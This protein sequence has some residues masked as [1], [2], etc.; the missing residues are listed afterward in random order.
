MH[1]SRQAS[2]HRAV[3]SWKYILKQSLCPLQLLF[4]KHS[5]SKV[6]KMTGC[7]GKVKRDHRLKGLST[8]RVWH[9]LIVAVL[10]SWIKIQLQGKP[11]HLLLVKM[12]QWVTDLVFG[13]FAA[14]REGHLQAFS[15]G[16]TGQ[17][18]QLSCSLPRANG[19]FSSL[20]LLSGSLL[21][22]GRQY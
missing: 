13:L 17:A 18:W 8:R 16:I 19:P 10:K 11:S 21:F 12:Q 15:S 5:V 9:S 3:Q 20:L 7:F 2:S 6:M 14:C 22:L 1:V 4:V